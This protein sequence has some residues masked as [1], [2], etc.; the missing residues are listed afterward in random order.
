MSELIPDSWRFSEE[1]TKCCHAP[2]RSSKRGPITNILLWLD[3]Y[4][5]MASVLISKF[6]D[7]A[8]EL[9]AYQRTIIVAQRDFEGDAWVTYDTCYRR[10][11]ANRKSLDWSRLDF[12]LYNQAFAGRARTKNRCKLCLSEFHITADCPLA[13]DQ[14]RTGSSES[15]NY[16]SFPKAE[17]GFSYQSC[18][19]GSLQPGSSV[20]I[21]QLYNNDK[22]NCCRYSRCRY[23]H[24]CANRWCHGPHPRSECTSQKAEPRKRPRSPLKHRIV[25]HITPRPGRPA[26][27]LIQQ[28]HTELIAA[29]YPIKLSS[30]FNQTTHAITCYSTYAV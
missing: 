28:C 23:A 4:S 16:M 5:T 3:C 24:L 6:S 10:Q 12:R 26:Q 14:R 15:G 20:E 18:P 9:W 21:C 17:L 11:A 25:I 13:P 29:M 30:P 22:G 2:R 7:K 27:E 19:E 8:Q 1:E